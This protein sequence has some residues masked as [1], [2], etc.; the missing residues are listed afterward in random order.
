MT[1]KSTRGK[2]SILFFIASLFL[3]MQVNAQN[4][5]C[6][7]IIKKKTYDFDASTV[8]AGKI[9]CID[10]GVR[11]SNLVIRNINGTKANKIIIRNCALGKSI[12]K[13]TKGLSFGIKIQNSKNFRITG[14]G[15]SGTLYG[16]LV[17]SSHIGVS[18]EALSTDFEIDHLE[19]KN[20]NFAGIMAKTDSSG[21]RTT[22]FKMKNVSFH[23][24]YVHKTRDGEGFYIGNTSWAVNGVQHDIDSIEVYENI[25]DSTGSEGI[26]VGCTYSGNA[27]VYKNRITHAG[28]NPFRWDQDNGL[29]LGG[30]FSGKAYNNYI[31]GVK[32][33]GLIMTGPGNV[34][35]FNNVIAHYGEYGIYVGNATAENG[36]PYHFIHNNIIKGNAADTAFNFQ[37]GSGK[38]ANLFNNI[39][40]S[41]DTT[42]SRIIR[43]NGTIRQKGNVIRPSE[44]NY[45]FAD[46]GAGDYDLLAGSDA[47]NNGDN[48][49]DTFNVPEMDVDFEGRPRPAGGAYDA[50]AYE[51][52][53]S[54]QPTAGTVLYRVNAG[55]QN[56]T[57]TPLI[58][59]RDRQTQ[60]CAY[61]D[62][63]S[64]YF[65]TGSDNPWSGTNNT[66][67][68]SQIFS[69]IRFASAT[70]GPRNN[71][72]Y[73]FPV[74]NG[75]YQVNLYFAENTYTTG[76]RVF[77]V[78]IEGGLKL[79]N[80]DVYVAA[81]GQRIARKESFIVQVSDGNL[82][83]H[84]INV[85]GAAQVNGI[86]IVTADEE[87]TITRS[88][89]QPVPVSSFS[90]LNNA[91]KNIKIYPIPLENQI[92]I[93]R[94]VEGP[95]DNLRENVE[96]TLFNEMG[97]ILYRGKHRFSG[98]KLDPVNLSSVTLKPGVYFLGITGPS[99]RETFRLLKR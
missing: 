79:D 75:S 86:E 63:T 36:K 10:S 43:G 30:G 18:I 7:T 3:S 81:G 97:T 65:T 57:D 68:P 9:I 6:D 50:G 71:V 72:H 73:V 8:A 31:D 15:A 39:I 95:V 38:I 4:C 16:I 14:T 91:V 17:D 1:K 64:A 93:E 34:Y 23:H 80:Y 5:N 92:N 11:T 33:N 59:V 87:T 25:T 70:T 89:G 26:Q 35:I 41:T 56:V 55:G 76:Q 22:G 2:S 90:S 99:T 82:D 20:V 46:A 77:D 96:V 94:R 53:G 45:N 29:Q 61:W 54:G 74:T 85:T 27:R 52:Q 66:D 48:V 40:Q 69:T 83:V 28:I 42:N 51:Y 60:P 84:F 12:F 49:V 47:I 44:A 78:T 32:G 21:P 37:A 19:V 98:A 13:L 67:A 24:N 88:G 58:W 62:T